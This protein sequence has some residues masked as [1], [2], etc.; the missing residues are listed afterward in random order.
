MA[1]HIDI[2]IAPGRAKA[3][4]SLDP[5]LLIEQ[6]SVQA[7]MLSL[8]TSTKLDTN[9]M[10]A[11]DAQSIHDYV[12]S[13]MSFLGNVTAQIPVQAPDLLTGDALVA[14]EIAI[15]SG[16]SWLDKTLPMVVGD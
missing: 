12:R 2:F 16:R 1:T 13:T 9:T 15:K 14:V 7:A 5:R 6:I 11:A 8:V 3:L 10:T 4:M